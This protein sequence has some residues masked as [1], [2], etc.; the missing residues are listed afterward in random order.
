MLHE[1]HMQK[2]Q[3]SLQHDR[4]VEELHDTQRSEIKA[5]ELRFRERHEKDI[6]VKKSD[7]HIYGCRKCCV[8]PWN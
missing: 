7:M 8:I 6:K 4:D 1:M 3:A 5:L 2:E